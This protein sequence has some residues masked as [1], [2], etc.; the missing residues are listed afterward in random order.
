VDWVTEKEQA[1]E[2]AKNLGIRLETSTST[3]GL[4]RITIWDGKDGIITRPAAEIDAWFFALVN[5][6][7]LSD[8]REE[9]Y[10]TWSDWEPVV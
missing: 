6:K 10:R 2:L 1:V 3:D 9:S 7:V 5:L 8:R 4:M